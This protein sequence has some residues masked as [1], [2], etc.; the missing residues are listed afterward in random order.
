MVGCNQRDM[1]RSVSRSDR[2]RA[3]RRRARVLRIRRETGLLTRIF[4]PPRSR[5]RKRC[6]I[7]GLNQCDV[8]P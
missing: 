8:V 7:C 3:K 5:K 2:E 6:P 4:G 1:D